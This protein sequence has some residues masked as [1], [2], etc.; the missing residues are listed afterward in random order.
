MFGITIDGGGVGGIGPATF[1]DTVHL[2][3]H[4]DFVAGTSVG[5]M[6]AAQIAIG[7]PYSQLPG[8]FFAMA[9]DIF[10]EPPLQWRLDPR[11]PMYQS[12][13]LD[14]VL[15]NVLGANTRICDLDMPIFVVAH[16]W[17]RGRVKVWDKTDC[18]L[19]RDVVAASC[20]APTWFPPRGGF[21]DGGTLA[22]NPAMCAITGMMSKHGARLDDIWLLSLGTNGDYWKDPEISVNTGKLAWASLLLGSPTRGNEE[23]ATFQSRALLGSRMLRIE[24]ILSQDYKLDDLG[25]MSECYKIWRALADMRSDEILDFIKRMSLHLA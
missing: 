23:L 10:V 9:G 1:L 14:A 20:S 21:A 12:K 25:Y 2:L 13:G 24:P 3:P 19:L 16:D 22:N 17:K 5:S 7:V 11:K 18:E 15:K 8:N 6:V 4:P